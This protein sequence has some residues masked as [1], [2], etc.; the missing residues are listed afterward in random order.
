MS[1]GI[2]CLQS[3]PPARL[4][5]LFECFLSESDERSSQ[6]DSLSSETPGISPCF[7]GNTW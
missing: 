2:K 3:I 5:Q 4:K 7:R 1:L 6:T